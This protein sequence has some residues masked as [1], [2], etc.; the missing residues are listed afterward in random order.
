MGGGWRASLAV[1]GA[2]G[3]ARDVGVAATAT[4]AAAAAAATRGVEPFLADALGTLRYIA[5]HTPHDSLAYQAVRALGDCGQQLATRFHADPAVQFRL[6]SAA[7]VAEAPAEGYAEAAW[8]L[9]WAPLSAA[10]LELAGDAREGIHAAA[11][12]VLMALLHAHGG[13]FSALTW[14]RVAGAVLPQLLLGGAGGDSRWM[15]VRTAAGLR[16]LC[17]LVASHAESAAAVLP[18]TL[19][20][21]VRALAHP[22]LEVRELSLR[23]TPEPSPVCMLLFA[24]TASAR[25]FG[26]LG[27]MATCSQ[28][29]PRRLPAPQVATAAAE[30]VVA[31]L[32]AAPTLPDA[33]WDALVL[34]LRRTN[35]A[36]LHAA[37]LHNAAVGPAARSPLFP[38]ASAPS[39][40]A[41]SSSSSSSSSA[42]SPALLPRAHSAPPPQRIRVELRVVAGKG[43]RKSAVAVTLRASPPASPPTAALTLLRVSG[44]EA[45]ASV[46]DSMAAHAL[47]A[48][49][50]APP[51]RAHQVRWLVQ[52]ALDGCLARTL[53]TLAARLAKEG[54]HDLVLLLQ[55]CPPGLRS[56]SSEREAGGRAREVER[57][58]PSNYPRTRPG[59]CHNHSNTMP[60]CAR[61]CS[62]AG[63]AC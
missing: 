5:L 55:R 30:A 44:E 56:L 22:A 9:L 32:Q 13:R 14:R 7:A 57:P 11:L 48:L 20:F 10:L 36:A 54:R 12:E 51:T 47:E 39:P 24:P 43:K 1:L 59:G 2:A 4:A 6:L 49:R 25:G 62:L 28:T 63:W 35:S 42:P 21:L 3:V 18:R 26:G 58:L 23:D 15:R 45:E 27:R 50:C 34:M 46:D 38:L 33:Q 29:G 41:S 53:P 61:Q 40:L 60:C 19:Q 52:Y 31:L 8:A 16:P 17:A 37:I